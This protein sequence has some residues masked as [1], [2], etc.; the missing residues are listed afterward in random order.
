MRGLKADGVVN[1]EPTDDTL[2]LAHMGW[3]F[4]K[5]DFEGKAC[6][7]GA[8]AENV[9]AIEKAI[10]VIPGLN[11]MGTAGRIDPPPPASASPSLNIGGVIESEPWNHYRA[12]QC[13][14][15]STCVHM[16]LSDESG[17]GLSRNLR[18]GR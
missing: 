7:S 14:F 16:F 8:K 1:C 18:R 15:L 3:V 4:F 12:G 17:Y 2:I 13:S 9:S 5:V 10:K 11:E 6:H